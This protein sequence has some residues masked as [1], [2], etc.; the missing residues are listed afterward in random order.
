MSVVKYLGYIDVAK[1]IAKQNKCAL[2]LGSATPDINTYY[3]AKSGKIELIR[4]TKRAIN[5]KLPEIEI[6]DLRQ[7][8]RQGWMEEVLII[9][10]CR[11]KREMK[12]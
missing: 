7:E 11:N 6:G 1:Y 5:S 12:E 9:R 4:L 2:L 10:R 3:K 8:L